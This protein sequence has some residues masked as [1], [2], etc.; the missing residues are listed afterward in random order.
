[1][2]AQDIAAASLPVTITLFVLAA[3]ARAV[4]AARVGAS[5]VD[6][7]AGPDAPPAH[8][9]TPP[10]SPSGALWAA[11]DRDEPGPRQGLWSR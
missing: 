1:M 11:P 7:P 3:G 8:A 2:S 6:A 4:L 9:E 10:A 5:R